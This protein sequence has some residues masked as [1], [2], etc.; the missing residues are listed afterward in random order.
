MSALCLEERSVTRSNAS[1]NNLCNQP[2]GKRR[3]ILVARKTGTGRRV[4]IKLVLEILKL[5]LI[6]RSEPSLKRDVA[7]SCKMLVTGH[8]PMQCT[9][10][11]LWSLLSSIL[12]TF[13]EY[14]TIN[15]VIQSNT[16][17]GCRV[18]YYLINNNDILAVPGHAL[19]W[20]SPIPSRP[21][22]SR[23]VPSRI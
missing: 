16:T 7:G 22:P 4:I 13:Q 17:R 19:L 9:N 3:R 12:C 1:H 21:N 8:R 23:P 14:H 5:R 20:L 6:F 11:L 2:Q 15:K 18:L 10:T